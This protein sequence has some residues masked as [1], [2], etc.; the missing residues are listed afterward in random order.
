MKTCHIPRIVL[1][2]PQSS[3]GKTTVVTGILA[4]L[5]K[6][7]LK[8]QPFKIGPDY[9]DPSYHAIAADRPGHNLD[10]W[11]V[12]KKKI[13]QLFAGYS[14]NADMAVVE[15]VMGLYDG[16]Q[17]GVS[18][19]AEL[20]KILKAPVIL[21]INCRSMGDSAAA[22]AL[23]FKTYDKDVDFAGVILNCLGSATHEQ[24]I[25][26]AMQKLE[27][28]VF[29]AIRRDDEMKMPERHLG[30]TPAGEKDTTEKIAYIAEKIAAQVDLPGIIKIAQAAP[31]VSFTESEVLP[32]INKTVKIAVARDKAFSFYY[33]AGLDVLKSLGA[34]IEFFSPIADK[35]LPECDAVILGGGFPELFVDEL[36]QN[37]SMLESLR[38]ADASGMPI[39]A[40]CGGFMYL[41]QTIKDFDGKVWKMAGII[42]AHAVMQRKLQ[43][44]GYVTA[45][46]VGNNI[47]MADGKTI[48]GHE[49]HFSVQ[50][51]PDDDSTFPWA[52]VFTK[53]RTNAQYKAGYSRNNVLASYLHLHFFGAVSAAKQFVQK[54]YEYKAG[55]KK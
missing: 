9:I 25:R 21:V 28:P 36:S 54:A 35:K 7:G 19:T 42:P 18:S 6:K 43:T 49:F 50:E 23:G 29:G 44:V 51:N 46:A 16:G 55:N 12:D 37:A 17:N 3:S 13:S 39:Y 5:N 32:E 34:Q 24:M 22:L 15:G 30:L 47:L 38:Q 8:V 41:M 1:A 52:F 27:I 10:T 45:Q 48:H 33:A 20:A 26:D 4:V 40:E 14:Y 53:N 2:A 31:A 11:L